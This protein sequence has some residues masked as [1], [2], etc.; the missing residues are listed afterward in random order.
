LINW[1]TNPE[2]SGWWSRATGYFAPNIAA[3]DTPEMKA[4]MA[5]NPDAEVAVRQLAYAK[6]WFATYKTV[7]V[8]KTLEDEVMLVLNGKKQPKEAL[9]AAQKAADET[10]K[11]YNAETSLKLP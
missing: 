11:P 1:V 7:P 9:V 8:R 4:F 10:L 2:K 3:Y 6:P 5:Q